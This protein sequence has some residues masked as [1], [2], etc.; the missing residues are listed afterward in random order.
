MSNVFLGEPS[1]YIK[2]WFIET[3]PSWPAYTTLQFTN[4]STL[5]KEIQGAATWKNIGVKSDYQS[6]DNTLKYIKIGT[7]V[8]G[9]EGGALSNCLALE[10]I[11]LPNTIKYISDTQNGGRAI[12]GCSSLTSINIPNSVTSIGSHAFEN[13]Y[14]LPSINIPSSI[15]SIEI[16]TFANCSSLTSINIPNSVTSI[17]SQAF[18]QCFS[19]PSINI[20]SSVSSLGNGTFINCRSLTLIVFEGKAMSDVTSM[21]NY[22]W[23]ASITAIVPGIS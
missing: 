13:C 1:E 3:F 5:T 2:N 7:D 20:P 22:P 10:K 6:D 19:L 18:Q 8:S 16:N 4:G 17:G 12:G 15:S 11:E 23:G 14:S 21:A 9:I